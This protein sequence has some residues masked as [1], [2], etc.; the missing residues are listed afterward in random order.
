MERRGF[1]GRLLGAPA[2]KATLGE[3]LSSDAITLIGEPERV[4]PLRPD[5]GH[6]LPRPQNIAAIQ[7]GDLPTARER[8]IICF[9][10]DPDSH[11]PYLKGRR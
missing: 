7:A 4:L 6:V 5:V 8:T 1:L 2:I 3:P 9:C 11:Y 10:A